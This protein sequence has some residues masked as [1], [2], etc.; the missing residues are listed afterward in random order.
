VGEAIDFDAELRLI[1]KEV[2]C[3]WADWVLAAELEAFRTPSKNIPKPP[4][5]RR[6]SLA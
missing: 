5:R 6:H 2:E 4:L 1:T 3:V